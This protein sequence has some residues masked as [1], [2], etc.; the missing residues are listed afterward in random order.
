VVQVTGRIERG[1]VRTADEV[2]IVGGSEGC[3]LTR[4]TG[5]EACRRQPVEE[6][7]AGMNVGL[8]LPGAAAGAVERGHVLAAP[9]SITVHSAFVADI[10]PLSEEQGG[11]EVLTG[12]VLDC[13]IHAG[14]VKGT[15]TLPGELDA[16]RPLHM[17]AVT[18]T[19]ERPVALEA[20]R[21]FAFRHRGRAA[22]SGT[23]TRLLP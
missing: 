12:D 11:S 10:A 22:G 9:G 13:H 18:L 3:S 23:V 15:V 7:T 14:A 21:S 16:L 5:I 1:R 20:G 17:A 6:A 2:E 8:L 4:V 19:L